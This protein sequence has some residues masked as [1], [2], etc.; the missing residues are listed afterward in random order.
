LV[1]ESSLGSLII[2][3]KSVDFLLGEAVDEI[4][5]QNNGA[6]DEIRNVESLQLDFGIIRD[7]TE[8]LSD[9]NKLGKRI[10]SIRLWQK[11]GVFCP[12]I[13]SCHLT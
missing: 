3:K 12:P 11:G 10:T 13:T 9:A 5:N 8:N 4:P 1:L 7:A 6:V 2:Q